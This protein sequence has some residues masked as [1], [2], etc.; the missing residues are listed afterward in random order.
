MP[1]EGLVDRVVDDLPDQVVQTADVGVPDVHRRPAP[2]G[3]Q[4]L[5]WWKQGR[6]DEI[7]RYCREDVRILRDLFDHA[8][9][10]GHLIFKTKGGERVKLPMKLHVPEILETARTE[11]A[12]AAF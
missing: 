6:I 9:E 11:A 1:R 5:E 12:D 8:R 2:D 4:S 7:E 3:L 10:R